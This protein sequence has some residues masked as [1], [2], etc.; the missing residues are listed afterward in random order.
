MEPLL[1]DLG[2]ARQIEHAEAQAGAAATEAMA[3]LAP[4]KGA[5]VE[6]IAGGYALYAGAGSPVTQAVGLGLEGGVS[7]AEFARLEAFYLA[8]GE[9]VRVEACPLADPTLFEHFGRA[10][11]RATEFTNVMALR[12]PARPP[13]GAAADVRVAR[14]EQAQIEVWAATVTL[15]FSE[16]QPEPEGLPDLLKVFALAEGAECFL[17]FVNGEVAGGATLSVRNGVAGLFGASTLPAFR[18]RGV[19]AALLQARIARGQEAGCAIAACL[20]H[21]GSSSARNIERQGFRVLYTRVK[22]E[23][24]ETAR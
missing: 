8:R 18:R 20:A 19:Q 6:R 17:A 23:S 1:L 9:P 12:L 5:A 21:P 15:G 14:A 13:E 11:Y 22:F 3:R 7:E 24:R 10:G 4:G 2:L 16:G